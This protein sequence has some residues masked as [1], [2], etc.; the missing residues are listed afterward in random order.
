V[1]KT[2]RLNNG[3]FG[4]SISKKIENNSGYDIYDR[5]INLTNMIIYIFILSLPLKSSSLWKK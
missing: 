4:K 3:K 5:I 1:I 2:L